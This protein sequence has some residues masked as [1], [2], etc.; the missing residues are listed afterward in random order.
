MCP[1]KIIFT[2]NAVFIVW[3]KTYNAMRNKMT[4]KIYLKSPMYMI[5]NYEMDKQEH[6]SCFSSVS[7][8]L[9]YY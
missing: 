5:Y 6:L 3:S 4:N 2:V 9:K 1:S 7:K 8:T